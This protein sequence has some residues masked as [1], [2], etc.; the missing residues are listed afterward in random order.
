MSKLLE[1]ITELDPTDFI[2]VRDTDASDILAGQTN[3]ALFMASLGST[4]DVITADQRIL[5]QQ[6]FAAVTNPQ[7]SDAE[8]KKALMMLRAPQPVK[9]LAGMLS[10]YDWNFVEQAR[11]IRGYVVANLLEE[12]KHPDAKIRLK[13]LQLL[14]TVSEVGAFTERI[15]ITKKDASVDELEAKI[16]EKL[17]RLGGLTHSI[18]AAATQIQDVQENQ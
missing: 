9:H 12:S 14:G 13:A 16:R 1:H 7:Q 3:T 17:S 8:K 5:A 15:E 4:D 2:D 10:E 18:P 11:E 6:A